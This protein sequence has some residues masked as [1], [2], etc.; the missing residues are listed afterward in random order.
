V[1]LFQ[2]THADVKE[3][4][5]SIRTNPHLFVF[6][7]SGR[8]EHARYNEEDNYVNEDQNGSKYLQEF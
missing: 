4:C 8:Y 2:Q 7:S 1:L 6:D 5:R 3:G